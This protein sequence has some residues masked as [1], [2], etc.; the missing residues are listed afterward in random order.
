[1]NELRKN[2]MNY[3]K[4]NK[5]SRYGSTAII[6][7]AIFMIMLYTTPYILM[8]TGVVTSTLGITACWLTMGFAIA[9]IGMGMMHDANH[10]SFSKNKRANYILSK[11]LYLVGGFPPT[12]RHQHNTLH[13]G[14]TNIDGYDDDI[15]PIGLLRFSPHKKL[16]KVHKYQYLY[17]WFLY[18]LMTLS[19]VLNK[20]FKQVIKYAKQK[21]KLHAK[22]SLPVLFADLIVSKA[23]YYAIILVI[24]LL[25]M[26]SS[27]YAIVLYFLLMQ[28]VAGLFLGIIF[29]TAHVMPDSEFN[30]PNEEGVIEHDYSVHQLLNTTNYSPNSRF[31]S[32]FVGGLNYQ[33]EHHLFPS[34]SH[35]H[36]KK[37]ATIVK[38]TAEKHN[39]PYNVEKTF[40]SALINHA[41]TLKR[42]GVA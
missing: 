9:G 31:F 10:S 42:L 40:F 5:I 34:I 21:T 11:S 8:I 36:Y 25:T 41:R 24:P 37:L 39:I 32:W 20:D 17:A 7:K 15:A 38:E 14:H 6:F 16:K 35:V 12:W 2:V 30:L 18:G 28:F 26:E 29:Q 22:N 19:W 3:F 13:H 27:W 1:M 33:I 4:E 23:I